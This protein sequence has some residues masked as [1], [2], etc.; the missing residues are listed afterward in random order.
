MNILYYDCFSGISGDM[1]LGAMIDLGV[2]AQDIK[3]ELAQLGLASEYDLAITSD[4]R[5][6]ISGTKVRVIS[7]VHEHGNHDHGHRN[8][9]DIQTIIT[10]SGLSRQVKQ[11]SLAMFEKLARAEAKVHGTPIHRVHFHEVGAIDALVDIV[12]A[13]ICFHLLDVDVVWSS[14][15]EL[16]GGYVTCAHGTMPVPAP[17]TVELLTGSPTTRGR[18]ETELTTPTGATILTSLVQRFTDTPAM[19]ITRTGY[20]IG[21]KQLALPNVLRVHLAKVKDESAGWQTG[22]VTMLE[23]LV[24]DM[25]PEALGVVME[26]L[27]EA[28][29][30]DVSFTPVIMKKNRPGTRVSV[31]CDHDDEERCKRLLFT[32]TTTLGLTS[33]TLEKSFL[34][35][36]YESLETRLGIVTMKHALMDGKV[37]RSKPELEDCKMLARQ[38]GLSLAEVWQEIARTQS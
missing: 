3:D 22:S 25:T 9:K 29:V 31:L 2:N 4:S 35:R 23:C 8:L 33:R 26:I 13:A 19:T 15:V 37:I 1:N 28:G 30:R 14:S 10:E 5:Q 7:N 32:H 24:D 17:A 38:H 34:P 20:G 27:L 36:T 16:G 11:T 12:G 18:V 21:H 6:G